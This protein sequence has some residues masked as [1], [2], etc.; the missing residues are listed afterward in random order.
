MQE[1][2]LNVGWLTLGRGKKLAEVSAEGH[3]WIREMEKICFNKL[4]FRK[5]DT[6]YGTLSAHA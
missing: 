3:T 1:E 6:R 2:G 4:R 5:I